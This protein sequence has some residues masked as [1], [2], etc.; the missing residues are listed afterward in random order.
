MRLGLE[1]GQYT[2][3]AAVECGI[4]GTPISGELLV[5]DGVAE[6][7]RPL[8]ER[9][10]DPCQ[11]G[12]FGYNPLSSDV[13]TQAQ[14]T[15]LLKALIPLAAEAG[16]PYIVIGPGNYHP[17]GFGGCDARNFTEEAL[18]TMARALEPLLQLAVRYQVRLSVEAYLKGAIGSAERFVSLW[19]RIGSDAL[20][21]NVDVTSLYDFR[22]MFNPS[23]TVRRTCTG[24]AGHYGLGHVKDVGLAEGFH[25]HIGLAPLGSSPTDWA[26]ALRLMD[27]HMPEDSWLILEHVSTP[28][29]AR[30][31]LK[32][33]REAATRAGVLL[34]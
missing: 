11:V 12:A 15:A 33:L 32:L 21:C 13:E 3:D 6:T 9:G 19:K 25:I 20:R 14:Q 4:K 2:L 31:S 16:C 23:E 8:R 18:D 1:A 30:A 7:L 28:E 22:D 26:E 24:L 17:S 27:P 10:L 34:D 29:E 5:R